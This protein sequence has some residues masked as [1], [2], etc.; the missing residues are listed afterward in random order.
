MT[1]RVE[2]V[3]AVCIGERGGVHQ[4]RWGR[5]GTRCHCLR[6]PA[7]LPAA[8]LAFSRFSFFLPVNAP[9][10]LPGKQPVLKAE[11]NMALFT[12]CQSYDV[13]QWHTITE[14][15]RVAIPK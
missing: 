13:L 3:T 11:L 14:S 10:Y 1:Q 5:W 6:M 15:C 12:N 4:R 2:C 9:R 8:R 7:S